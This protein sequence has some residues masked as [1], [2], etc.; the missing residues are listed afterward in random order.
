MHTVFVHT[1][2]YTYIHNYYNILQAQLDEQLVGLLTLTAAH[3]SKLLHQYIRDVDSDTQ[4]SSGLYA[5]ANNLAR[6]LVAEGTQRKARC[7]EVRMNYNYMY[8]NVCMCKN[9]MYILYV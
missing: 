5:A 4:V 9:S 7:H 1:Y 8:V 3:R 6:K 2:T